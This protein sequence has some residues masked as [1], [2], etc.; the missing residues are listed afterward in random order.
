LAVFW[1][2]WLKDERLAASSVL[3]AALLL[4]GLALYQWHVWPDRKLRGLLAFS[5]GIKKA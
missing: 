4:A 2:F 1:G 3:G 5:R